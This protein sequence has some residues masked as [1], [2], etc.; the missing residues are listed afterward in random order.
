MKNTYKLLK[1]NK[2]YCLKKDKIIKLKECDIPNCHRMNNC[3]KKS[4]RDLGVKK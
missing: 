2:C 3:L 1:K 4:H